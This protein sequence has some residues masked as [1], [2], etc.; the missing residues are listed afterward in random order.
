MRNRRA[1][2][3]AIGLEILML[4][5]SNNGYSHAKH[6]KQRSYKPV[7]SRYKVSFGQGSKKLIVTDIRFRYSFLF[8]HR[9]QQNLGFFI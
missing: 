7:K 2:I 6:V 1:L 3:F 5:M 4:N 9:I 8:G